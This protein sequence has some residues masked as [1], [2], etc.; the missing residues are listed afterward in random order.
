[1]PLPLTKL[2]DTQHGDMRCFS[3]HLIFGAQYEHQQSVLQCWVKHY[4]TSQT[5]VRTEP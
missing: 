1:M 4:A 2:Q 3:L 5:P